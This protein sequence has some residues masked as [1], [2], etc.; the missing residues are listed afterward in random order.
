MLRYLSPVMRFTSSKY[1]YD[2]KYTNLSLYSEN[3][4]G[5]LSHIAQH[6][7]KLGIDMVFVKSQLCN[8]WTKNKK[9]VLN[10]SIMK[11]NQERL[12]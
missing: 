6:F 7:S 5:S 1:F 10:V 12:N 2:D 11:Q 4:I 3:K 8:A 9:Y